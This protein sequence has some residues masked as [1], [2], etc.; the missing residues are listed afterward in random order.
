ME[1][2]LQ[3]YSVVLPDSSTFNWSS[4][5]GEGHTRLKSIMKVTRELGLGI[6]YWFT[7]SNVISPETILREIWIRADAQEELMVIYNGI[8]LILVRTI[9]LVEG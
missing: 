6:M 8:G 4:S 7:T 2:S 1:K 3:L 9:W 5:Q